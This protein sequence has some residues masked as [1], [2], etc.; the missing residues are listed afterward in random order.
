MHALDTDHQQIL[1]VLAARGIAS[2]HDLQQATRKSQP[3]VSRLLTDLS[4]HVV[5]LGKAR[6]TRYGVLKSIRG[7]AAQQPVWWTS[8]DGSV[9]RIGTLSF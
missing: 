3:T 8:E 1:G 6:S 9:R 5:T 2:S 7:L 4:R